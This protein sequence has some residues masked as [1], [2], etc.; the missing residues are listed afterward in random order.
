VE[1]PRVSNSHHCWHKR[2]NYHIVARTNVVDLTFQI[3]FR[4][5]THL[6]EASILGSAADTLLHPESTSDPTLVRYYLLERFGIAEDEI[7]VLVDYSCHP[8]ESFDI[9]RS[10]QRK[11]KVTLLE[12]VS[13]SVMSRRH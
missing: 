2:G 6:P 13:K 8:Q 10:I 5:A 1:K 9:R 11:V 4:P 3:V 12:Q 7:P